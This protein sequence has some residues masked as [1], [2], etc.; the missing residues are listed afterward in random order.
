MISFVGAKMT[1]ISDE[2]FKR[3][4]ALWDSH[5]VGVCIREFFGKGIQMWVR[6]SKATCCC[7][8]LEINHGEILNHLTPIW[9]TVPS[10]TWAPLEQCSQALNLQTSWCMTSS[11]SGLTNRCTTWNNAAGRLEPLHIPCKSYEGVAGES[12]ESLSGIRHI[13]KPIYLVARR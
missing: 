9:L 2:K 1:I 8:T 4:G 7:R 3:Q 12:L 10:S 11:G 5:E 6:S 13:Y